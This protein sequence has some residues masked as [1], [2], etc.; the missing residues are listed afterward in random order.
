MAGV[1]KNASK[2]L[3]AELGVAKEVLH[4]AEAALTEKREGAH[5]VTP[6]RV[7]SGTFGRDRGGQLGRPHRG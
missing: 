7:E 2:G 1:A 6:L 3:A 5:D 4:F